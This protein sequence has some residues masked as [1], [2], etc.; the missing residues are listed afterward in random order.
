MFLRWQTHYARRW[1]PTH[2]D[3]SPENDSPTH[4]NGLFVLVCMTSENFSNPKKYKIFSDLFYL[5]YYIDFISKT[6]YWIVGR[7]LLQIPESRTHKLIPVWKNQNRSL[8]DNEVERRGRGKTLCSVPG[9]K[10]ALPS[11]IITARGKELLCVWQ[12]F[13]TGQT[14]PS[15]RSVT[16]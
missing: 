7:K 1:T 8:P 16:V 10:H 12:C 14:S 9:I 15:A 4:R 2:I 11:Y 13:F 6:S 3:R 5:S